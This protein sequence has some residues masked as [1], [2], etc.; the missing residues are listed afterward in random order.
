MVLTV[1]VSLQDYTA[2][3]YAK[4]LGRA[5]TSQIKKKV[6]NLSASPIKEVCVNIS[7]ANGNDLGVQTFA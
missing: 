1:K 5:I 4:K 6:G 2:E 7:D 3:E